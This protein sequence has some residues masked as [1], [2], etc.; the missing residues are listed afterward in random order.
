MGYI[1]SDLATELAPLIDNEDRIFL[2]EFIRKNEH[3]EHNQVGLTVRIVE[4]T[5]LWS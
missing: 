5:H 4:T 2:A 3:P 1:P